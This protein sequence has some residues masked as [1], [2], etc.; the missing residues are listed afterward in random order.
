MTR[1]RIQVSLAPKRAHKKSWWK[2]LVLTMITLHI[3]VDSS[4]RP[5]PT[6]DPTRARTMDDMEVLLSGVWYLDT[7]FNEL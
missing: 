2:W 1:F 3:M 5:K 4:T 6:K 7:C